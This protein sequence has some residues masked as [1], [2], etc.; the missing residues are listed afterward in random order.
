MNAFYDGHY[1]PFLAALVHVHARLLTDRYLAPHAAYYTRSMTRSAYAQFL[2]SYRSVSL[3]TMATAF[4]VSPSFLDGELSRLIA[5]GR[6]NAK[7]DAVAGTVVTTVPDAK[8][9]QYGELLKAGDALLN[10]VQKLTRVIT[11]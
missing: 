2:T 8:A 5:A 3:A 4:G 10:R 11:S 1:A 7:I 6:I 9:G